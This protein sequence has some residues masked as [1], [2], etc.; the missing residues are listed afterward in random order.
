[1]VSNQEVALCAP[2][3]YSAKVRLTYYYRMGNQKNLN[4]RDSHINTMQPR[5]LIAH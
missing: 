3:L 2:H 4:H 5:Y 1:M